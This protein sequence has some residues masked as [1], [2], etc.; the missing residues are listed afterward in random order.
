MLDR[1][2]DH[3]ARLAARRAPDLETGRAGVGRAEL[4][5]ENENLQVA[6]AHACRLDDPAVLADLAFDLV[7]YWFQTAR[8]ADGDQWLGTSRGPPDRPGCR[9][10][11]TAPV[12][13]GLPQLLL[14]QLRPVGRVGPGRDGGRCR[15]RRSGGLRPVRWT[16]AAISCSSA[17][18]WARCRSSRRPSPVREPPTTGGGRSTSSRRSASRYLYADR[19]DDAERSFD[20]ARDLGLCGNN[21]FF[22][23]WHWNARIWIEHRRGSRRRRRCIRRDH[24]RRRLGRPHDDRLGPHLRR[25]RPAPSRWPPAGPRARRRR[26]ARPSPIAAAR[27]SHTSCSTWPRRTPISGPASAIPPGS[28]GS[29]PTTGVPITSPSPKPSPSRSSPSARPCRA[30][31][32]RPIGRPTRTARRPPAEPV[33]GRIGLARSTRWPPCRPA[34]PTTRPTP[35][36]PRSSVWHG[37]PYDVQILEA[38]DVLAWASA[39]GGQAETAGRLLTTTTRVT[40]PARVGHRRLRGALATSARDARDRHRRV[41]RRRTLGGRTRPSTKR[42]P[43]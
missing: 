16:S 1:H 41:P 40:S 43:G 34:T 5:R 8:F 7:F 13:P 32:M 29:T 38:L 12:G 24:R 39:A 22:V 37:Q 28:C 26:A 27:C 33:A 21:P 35:A 36:G 42:L 2:L 19:Y 30:T 14:R 31:R 20:A 18:R 10:A 3:F 9:P 6:L 11:W 23:A 4:E 15:G 17:I 25:A